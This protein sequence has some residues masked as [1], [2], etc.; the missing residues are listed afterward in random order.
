MKKEY[1]MSEQDKKI[2]KEKIEQNRRKRKYKST[3]GEEDELPIKKSVLVDYVNS[4]PEEVSIDNTSVKEMV[5][6]IVNGRERISRFMK[7]K[8]DTLEV[9]EKI[10]KSPEDAL[11]LISHLI[12]NPADALVII[13]KIMDSPFD[14]LSVF[15]QFLFSTT[16]A[17]SVN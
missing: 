5:D 8:K 15:N 13:Q 10:I 16:D 6:S 9:M 1:I 11:T 7:T 2:K 12:S 14:A 17:L 3:S 4:T